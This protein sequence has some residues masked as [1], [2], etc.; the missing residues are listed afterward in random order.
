[1]TTSPFEEK[2]AEAYDRESAYEILAARYMG[3]GVQQTQVVQP[4]QSFSGQTGSAAQPEPS[5]QPMT[6]SVYNPQTGT[7]EVQELP[8]MQQPVYAQPA[9]Q[10]QPVQQ[11]QA[12]AAPGGQ[13]PVLVWD[14]ATGQYIPQQ[15]P[16]NMAVAE[17]PVQTAKPAAK[18]KETNAKPQKTYLQT[19]IDSFAK[20]AT[21]S[22]GRETGRTITRTILGILGIKTTG[23]R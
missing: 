5:Y 23:R 12:P 13:P 17:A 10:A 21:T 20:S 9:Q 6:F 16:Q 11:T 2:Y 14:P 15:A 18:P 8:Q 3:E 7:Y 19:M 1:M 4:I 22:A